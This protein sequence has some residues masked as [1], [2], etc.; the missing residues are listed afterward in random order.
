MF[1]KKNKVKLLGRLKKRSDFLHV[2]RAGRKW[3]AKGMVVEICPNEEQGL[4][5]GLTVS[6]RVSKLAVNRNRVKRRLRAVACDVL[7]DYTA[8]NLD[9]VLIGRA[10]TARRDY[11]DL[12]NDL[13][14]CLSKMGV[15][16]EG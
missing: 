5:Y 9:V 7:P 12:L 11:Q 15:K 14:W 10:E 8:Q 2:Q 16:Q 6:K 4:R 13:R 1:A 3:T